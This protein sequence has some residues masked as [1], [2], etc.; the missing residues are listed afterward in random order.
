MFWR[1]AGLVSVVFGT[2]LALAAVPSWVAAASFSAL[3]GIAPRAVSADGS[4]VVG[5]RRNA[6]SYS[7][8]VRWDASTGVAPLG[9]LGSGELSQSAAAFGVSRDG[10]VIAGVAASPIASREAFRWSASEGI[11]GLGDLLGGGFSSDAAAISDDGLTI[12]GRSLIMRNTGVLGAGA[13]RWTAADGMQ[14]LG[15]LT[16]R[17]QG[18]AA[19]GVSADGSVI[20]GESVSTRG[21]A[22]AFR[23]DHEV[24]MRGIGFLPGGNVSIAR[25]T[26]G[27]GG[28]IIGMGRS[29]NGTEA[30]RWD[31]VTG[32][33]GLGDLPGGGFSS[34]ATDVSADGSIIV[35]SGT[36]GP[37]T[38]AIIWDVENGIRDL[39]VVLSLMGV[40]VSGWRLSKAWG[41]SAD[42]RTIVGTGTNP[43][44]EAGGWIVVVPEPSAALLLGLGLAF[45]GRRQG[46]S[47]RKASVAFRAAA[48]L[49]ARR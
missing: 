7:E 19:N 20:V 46:D 1:S 28:V 25:G 11:Q 4:V 14:G 27:D 32:M 41:V 10:F 29:I 36:S 34:D 2:S 44:G 26:S 21:S 49:A 38:R 3:P 23:W 17:F 48:P 33:Q 47:G 39:E 6:Q 5:F 45:L 18:S 40:D 12:V 43:A 22:E 42:G 37:G 13:F 9:S 8:P 24:G 31:E 16:D 35:G 15:F 30:F